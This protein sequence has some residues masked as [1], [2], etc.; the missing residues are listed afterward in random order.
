MKLRMF[1]MGAALVSALAQAASPEAPGL[2]PTA[3][4]R[5]L[6][7]QDPSVAA[8][9]AGLEAARQ[10]AAMLEASPYEWMAKLSSQRRKVQNDA[11][12]QE[13]SAGIERSLRLPGK[14]SADRQLGSAVLAEAEAHYGEAIHETARE[15]LN[16]WLAWLAAEQASD[17]ASSNRLSIQENLAIVEKRLRA[18]DVAKLDLNLA[19]AELAEQKRTENDAK[20]QSQIAWAHL[21]ARFPQ[22]DQQ[23]N[24][25]PVPLQLKEEPAFWRER[26]L[27]ESDELKIAEAQFEKAK[28]HAQRLHAEKIPDPTVG[29]YT[30][31]EVGGRERI[32][33]ISVSI[34]FALPGGQRN[35]RADKSSQVAE[36]SR[37]EV[38]LKRRQLHAEINGSIINAQGHYESLQLA[39]AGAINAQSNAKLMQ[40]AYALGEL[41]LQAL[42][43]AR[44]QATSAMQNALSA[45]VAAASS[46]YRLL[47]DAHL[48]WDLGHE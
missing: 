29:L 37:Y 20:I 3:M 26:I 12:Y 4:V 39:D 9:R 1:I 40:R 48:V 18:G 16:L 42:L 17:L 23:F 30:S 27:R 19:Q 33:G 35:R 38:E 14:A 22:F 5:A 25:L 43:A 36:M 15:L 10:D 21:Q 13:W 8:T 2:L 6:L 31:S 41:D 34:P 11:H 46:Y 47:I 7:E 45:R 28:A 44:R 24:R 32:T